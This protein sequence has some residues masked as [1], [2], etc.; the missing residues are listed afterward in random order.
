MQ[1]GLPEEGTGAAEAA[2]HRRPNWVRM[3]TD[4]KI[5]ALLAACPPSIRETNP[6]CPCG[7]AAALSARKFAKVNISK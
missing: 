3:L 5:A 6:D 4:V 2:L 1:V 7:A